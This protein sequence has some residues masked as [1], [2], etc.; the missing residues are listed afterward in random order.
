MTKIERMKELGELLKN[1]S[2]AYYQEDREIMD[3]FEY[4]RLYDELEALEKETGIVLGGSP[5]ISVGYEAVDELPK[6]RHETPMPTRC[7]FP[8]NWTG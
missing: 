4:D 3:N 2:K 8:G 1:A 6:E 7:C 5:T